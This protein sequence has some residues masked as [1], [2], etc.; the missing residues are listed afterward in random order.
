MG[1]QTVAITGFYDYGRM[2]SK[3]A[4]ELKQHFRPEFLNRVDDTIV[5]FCR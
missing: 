2:K 4:E 1:F 5:A 3:A